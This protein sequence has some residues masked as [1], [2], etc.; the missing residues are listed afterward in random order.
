MPRPRKH[1]RLRRQHQV[2]IFKPV[3]AR[4]SNCQ[5]VVLL[6]EELEALRLVE[7]EGCYQVQ[8]C[9]AMDVARSTFQRILA[10]AR[11]KVALALSEDMVIVVSARGARGIRVR[12]KCCSCG[13]NW[14]LQY[15]TN[16]QEP[17]EC[18]S[19]GSRAIKEA[20]KRQRRLHHNHNQSASGDHLQA[21]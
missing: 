19:C 5:M 10:E 2:K 6:P 8:A 21:L 4:L 13:E 12:W 20:Q 15:H 1:R 17:D 7:V 18:P 14:R 3:G 11:R 16:Y 9:E